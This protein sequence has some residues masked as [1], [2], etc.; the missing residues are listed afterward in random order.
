MFPDI[1]GDFM[2][3]ETASEICASFK[4]MH[5]NH[6]NISELYEIEAQIHEIKQGNMTINDTIHC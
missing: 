2:M 1:S 5:F 6:D 4:K 3:Y